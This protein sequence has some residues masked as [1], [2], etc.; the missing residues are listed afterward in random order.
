M[1][2]IIWK[3]GDPVYDSDL[4]ATFEPGQIIE[5][6]SIIGNQV[7]LKSEETEIQLANIGDLF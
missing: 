5:E 7:I 1:L 6:L 4:D 3:P 2:R